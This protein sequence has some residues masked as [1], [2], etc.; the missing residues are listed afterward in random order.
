MKSKIEE[1]K[2]DGG[3]NVGAAMDKTFAIIK[4]RKYKGRITSVL[5]LSDGNDPKAEENTKKL[6]EEYDI[7]DKFTINTFG[8]GS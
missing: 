8:Y 2:A 5:L 4:Q 1:I 7:H 6:K 3:T